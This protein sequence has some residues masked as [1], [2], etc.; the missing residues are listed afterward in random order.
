[1]ASFNTVSLPAGIPILPLINLSSGCPAA[2]LATSAGNML[3]VPESALD[4]DQTARSL[5]L[6]CGIVRWK[7][8]KIGLSESVIK[9]NT[10]YRG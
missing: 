3:E 9:R 10:K 1:M 7:Q 4:S 8:E 2:I 6:K 5:I